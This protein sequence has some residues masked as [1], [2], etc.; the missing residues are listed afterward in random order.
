M[1]MNN[2][3]RISCIQLDMKLGDVEYNYAEAL[4]LIRE[5]VKKKNP[6]LLFFPKHGQRVSIPRKTLRI[7]VTETA[8]G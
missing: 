2:K 3:M 4:R 7:I 6:T 1:T 8:R 5:T